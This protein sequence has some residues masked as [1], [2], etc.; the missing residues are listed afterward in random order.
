VRVASRGG[1][2]ASTL[3]QCSQPMFNAG[4]CNSSLLVCLPAPTPAPTATLAHAPTHRCTNA[5]APR[6]P[7]PL[8]HLLAGNLSQASTYSHP[9]NI[10]LQALDCSKATAMPPSP[11]LLPYYFPTSSTHAIP[12][13]ALPCR[14]PSPYACGIP[15]TR[16]FLQLLVTAPAASSSGSRL[17]WQSVLLALSRCY[18]S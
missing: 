8:S 10:L 14:L 16:R 4:S 9:D 13:R 6:A 7:N 17:E 2:Q 1:L 3:A 11:S 18:R 12:L 15:L 5:A